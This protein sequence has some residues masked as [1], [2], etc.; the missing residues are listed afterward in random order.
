VNVNVLCCDVE[1]EMR[2][3]ARGA[4]EWARAFHPDIEISL[5]DGSAELR[6]NGRCTNELRL[7]W[8]CALAN[9]ALLEKCKGSRAAVLSLLLG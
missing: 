8:H 7:I 1:G 6:S 2:S 3:H 5:N 4:A 9:E